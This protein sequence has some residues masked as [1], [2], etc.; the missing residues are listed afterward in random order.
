MNKR[1]SAQPDT[2][3]VI[4]ALRTAS[5]E[6][7]AAALKVLRN[8]SEKKKRKKT[9]FHGSD[10]FLSREEFEALCQASTPFY[11]LLFRLM[12]AHGLRVSEAIGLRPQDVA[13]GFLCVQRLKGSE[14]TRQPLLV[15]LS[16][17]LATGS[18]RIFPCHRSSAFLNFRK[19][20]AKVGIDRSRA[21][22]HC[23]RHSTICWMLNAGVP[24]HVVSHFVGHR[25]IQSTSM[26][27]NCSDT[28][29][30]AAAAKVMGGHLGP[31]S[32]TI[33]T[34]RRQENENDLQNAH[35]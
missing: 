17:R 14:F 25:S 8:G 34:F 6:A 20:A 29:A 27:M 35:A 23:I 30:S 19:A 28:T 22:P 1:R 31:S 12:L 7:L 15:D 11:A 26:Y 13:D 24:V 32:P 2:Q 21:H 5:P 18:Y 10:H 33:L 3:Q 4:N 16:A 9:R